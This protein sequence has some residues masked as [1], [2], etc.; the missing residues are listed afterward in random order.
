MAARNEAFLSLLSLTKSYGTNLIVNQLSLDLEQGEFISLLGPSGCG[1]TTTLRMIAGFVNPDSGEIHLGGHRIDTR[2]TDQRGATMVFQNYALFP[3]MTVDQN[4]AFG[5]RMK[6]IAR[7]EIAQRVGQVLELVRLS[8]FGQRYPRE[9]SGGQQQRVALARAIAPNPKL[10]LLD[11]PLSNLDAKL[12]KEL[13]RDL[14]EIHR[15]AGTTTVFVTHDL[16]EAFAMSDR[17]AVMNQG[18]IEQFDRPAT[19]FMAPRTKFISEFL[20]HSNV[21]TGTVRTNQAGQSVLDCDGA[22]VVLPAQPSVNIEKRFAIPGHLINVS[23]AANE[24]ENCFPARIQS[25]SYV[26]AAIHCDLLVL[27]RVL[28][29]TIPATLETLALKGHDDIHASWRA[30]SVIALGE[31]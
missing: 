17:V 20:G 14:V 18:H 2:P 8:G 4:V 25:L 9:L 24:E 6:K 10:L 15:N 5:L 16:E 26:G 28:H 31:D 1:K 29:A 19:I 22:E 23:V 7:D 30:S 11:E 3:H 13:R 27:G 21:L 12:R